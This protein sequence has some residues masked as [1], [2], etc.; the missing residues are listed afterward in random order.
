MSYWRKFF[1]IMLLVLSLPVQ[2]FAALSMKCETSHFGGEVTSAQDEHVSG[3]AHRHDMHVAAMADA[4][5]PA[6]HPGEAHHA[7]ACSTCASCCLGAGFPVGPTTATHADI[8]HSAVPLPPSVN[9]AS[10]LTS[11]IERPPRTFLV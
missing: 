8:A 3:S 10:F 1:V 7:H 11:G 6:H 4:S 9:V 5:H 2:S